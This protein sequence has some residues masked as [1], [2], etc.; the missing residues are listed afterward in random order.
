MLDE[1]N[2]SKMSSK[3]D[4][5]SGNYQIWTRKGH[6]WKI[7]FKANKLCEWLVIPFS[8]STAPSTFIRLMNQVFMP[9]IGKCVV[10]YLGDM[11]IY[12]KT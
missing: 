3:V 12:S 10:V 4:V 1:L 7:A 2:G 8:L 5:R 9:V 11:L 6:E